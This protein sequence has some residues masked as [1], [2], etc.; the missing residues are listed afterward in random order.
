MKTVIILAAA[1]LAGCASKGP[2]VCPPEATQLELKVPEELLR[3]PAQLKK[4]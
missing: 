2:V 4:L 1:L 3:P